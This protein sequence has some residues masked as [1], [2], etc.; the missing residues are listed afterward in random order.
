MTSLFDRARHAVTRRILHDPLYE[1]LLKASV[2]IDT[3]CGWPGWDSQPFWYV[4]PLNGDDANDGATS[5][6][7]L[8]T[9]AARQRRWGHP[10]NRIHIPTTVVYMSSLPDSDPIHYDVELDTGGS[11]QLEGMP[12]ILY[13]GTLMGQIATNRA[14]QIMQ[15]VSDVNFTAWGANFGNF[16][17]DSD[18]GARAVIGSDTNGVSPNYVRT[19]TFLQAQIVA[20]FPGTVV[21]PGPND[22]YSV[23]VPPRVLL[24]RMR[25]RSSGTSAL[26]APATADGAFIVNNMHIA[27]LGL[28]GLQTV[29][30]QGVWAVA[31]STHFGN[32]TIVGDG[33][34][35]RACSLEDVNVRDGSVLE[36]QACLC[37]GF[38]GLTVMDSGEATLD[39]DTLFDSTGG[40]YVLDGH[41]VCGTACW[42]FC[43]NVGA[44]QLDR[45]S[46]MDVLGMHDTTQLAWGTGNTQAGVL[47][48]SGSYLRWVDAGSLPT[49]NEGAGTPNEVNFP[50]ANK[51]WS[52]MPFV[53]TTSGTYG[54]VSA[55]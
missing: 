1:W 30:I 31:L 33:L 21:T 25:I 27:G 39:L 46:R 8:K 54:V 53:E 42:F 55:I 38:F 20:P 32:V 34:T 50:G 6:T 13:T 16:L 5:A 7:A 12:T 14:A 22:A 48:H 41:V 11:L 28:F 49:V 29:D 45:M 51:L 26:R 44:V 4:D 43:T 24:G 36:A 47:L 3:N 9:D 19:S 18:A 10:P 35:C 15:M 2:A 17:Y 23:L 52:D 37:W 40:L